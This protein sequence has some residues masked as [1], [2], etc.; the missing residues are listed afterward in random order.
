[1][2]GGTDSRA[3]ETPRNEDEPDRLRPD[4]R[5]SARFSAQAR[6]G[7]RPELLLRRELHRRGL[8]YR[9]QYAVPGLPRRT[10]DIAFTRA[11]LA[12]LVDGCFWHSCPEHQ[13]VPKANREWWKWKFATNEARDAD[14]DVRLTALGWAVIRL[15][16]HESQEVGANRIQ[17]WIEDLQQ[18]DQRPKNPSE[19]WTLDHTAKMEIEP[20]SYRHIP[21]TP[22]VRSNTSG[23]QR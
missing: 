6:E 11:R 8:R 18:R 7:T 5:L 23:S 13:V 20:I 14:T 4:A 1:M 19:F 15:W 10:V 9:V 17:K 21:A 12:V 3:E 2:S 16:E 22:D